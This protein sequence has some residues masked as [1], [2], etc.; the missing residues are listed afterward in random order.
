MK[1]VPDIIKLARRRLRDN[2]TEAESIV[3]NELKAKKL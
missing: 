2:Q 1:K 3:W